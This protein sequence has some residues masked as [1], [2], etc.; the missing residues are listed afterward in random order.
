MATNIYTRGAMQWWRRSVHFVAVTDHPISIRMSLKTRCPREARVR[1]GYLEMEMQ[2]VET[3]IAEELRTRITAD[4]MRA[5]YRT[6]FEATLDRY[7]VQQAATPFRAE[8]HAAI[9]LAYARYF[10]L[11]ASA[12]VPPEADEAL[13]DQLAHSGLSPKDADAL[14]VTVARH[15]SASPIGSNY[16]ASY[17]RSAGIKPT[18]DNLRTLSRV[19]AAA[20]RNACLAATE[21][22]DLPNPEA[23]VWPLPGAL[24]KLLDL[25]CREEEQATEPPP[26]LAPIPALTSLGAA[27][28]PTSPTIVTSASTASTGKIDV[29]LSKL[30]ATCLQRK[31]DDREWREERRRDV[32]AAVN[33]FLAACGDLMLSEIDQQACSAMTALFP[34]LPTRYGHTR[35]DIAG[36]MT[37]VLERGNVLR[38]LWKKDPVKA[39]RDQ[40]PTVGISDTT[41]N[42]HLTWLSALFTFADANGYVTPDV[43]LGKLRRKVKGRKGG[44]RLPWAETDLR[45][46]ISGPIWTGCKG[47]WNRLAPGDDVFHDGIYWGLPL[48]V[49]IGGR[50]EEPAGLMLADIFED[51]PI[52]YIHF[53]DNAYRQLKNDQ[54]DRKVPLSPA[55]IRLGFLDHVRAMRK[56]GHELLFPEFY[57]PK[58]S[59]SFDHIFYD[60]VFEPLRDFHFPNG[61]SQKRGRKDVDVHSIRTRVASFWRDRKFDPGLRQYLLGHVPDGETA[62]SYEEEPRLDL[63]LPLVTALGDLL[64]E[65]PVMP[66]RLRPT[67]WQKF[68]SIRGRRAK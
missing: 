32:D 49:C 31:I 20:Y 58:A 41:H 60:K 18:E 45:T 17:L 10:T 3:T 21:G 68:G 40:L 23:D 34:R 38:A 65:L 50:S 28:V 59:M 16:L 54:S 11:I 51:A 29:P 33:L 2:V 46:L 15:R 43:D 52:P 6:A 12:P 7:L 1:A 56:L 62:A 35:D 64:P 37:A 8:A 61:T 55:L 27:S 14:F 67:E 22:L 5:V 48:L 53:R 66:L 19:G 24:R 25:P 13:R 44:K 36:G 4:N 42:K 57:N 47:L 39:E 26:D 63:L 9:N 30:A